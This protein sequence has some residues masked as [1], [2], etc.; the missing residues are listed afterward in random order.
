MTGSWPVV[1]VDLEY[2]SFSPGVCASELW[3]T[4]YETDI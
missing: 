4:R 2:S 1:R 3:D